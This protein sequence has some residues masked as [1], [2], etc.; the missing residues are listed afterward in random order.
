MRLASGDGRALSPEAESAAKRID[1]GIILKALA[2]EQAL[3]VFLFVALYAI[4]CLLAAVT[5]WTQRSDRG[6]LR[7]WRRTVFLGA[8]IANTIS[9]AWLLAFL[10]DVKSHAV[11]TNFAATILLLMLGMGFLSAPLAMFGRKISR[12]LLGVNGVLL[13]VL[14]YALFMGMSM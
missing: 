14:W 11:Q 3:T 4:P 10:L 7:P 6:T 8:L 13:T 1:K 9:S 5:W 2:G 12:L